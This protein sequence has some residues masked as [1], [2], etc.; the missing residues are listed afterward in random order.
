MS[1]TGLHISNACMQAGRLAKARRGELALP[2]GYLRRPSEEVGF[3][4]DAQARSVM[5]L[6][7]DVL[8]RAGASGAISA[9]MGAYLVLYPKVRVHCILFLGFFIT[10]ITLP[11]YAMLLYW[12]ALQL[13]GSAPAIAGVQTA[14][15]VAFAAHLGG[16]VVGVALIKLF[17]KPDLLA[18]ARRQ[19]LMFA[20]SQPWRY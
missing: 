9:I 10:R 14:G 2:M 17:A 16:F 8:D 6:D 1:E 12:A 5:R 20:T 18:A 15:G 7:L 11:A 3:D 4:W 13:I 19:P